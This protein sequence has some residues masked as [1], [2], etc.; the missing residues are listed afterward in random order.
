MRCMH[1]CLAAFIVLQNFERKSHVQVAR[2]EVIGMHCSSCST[3]VEKAL[4]GRDGVKEATVSLSLNMAEVTYDP[5]HVTEV[6]TKNPIQ[7]CN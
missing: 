7:G 5:T 6:G 4:N 3:A 1:R 2:L